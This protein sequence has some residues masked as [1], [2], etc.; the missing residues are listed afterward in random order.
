MTPCGK[1]ACKTLIRN[2]IRCIAVV[3]MKE[4]ATTIDRHYQRLGTMRA[5]AVADAFAQ[6]NQGPQDSFHAQV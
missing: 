4:G 6:P 3:L 5:L 1:S 2:A